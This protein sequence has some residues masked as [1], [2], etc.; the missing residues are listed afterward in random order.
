[1]SV[2]V[3]S[4]SWW[5]IPPWVGLLPMIVTTSSIAWHQACT[6]AFTAA[7]S[8]WPPV[9]NGVGAVDSGGAGA[10]HV[11]GGCMA[12]LASILVGQRPQVRCPQVDAMSSVALHHV[13]CQCL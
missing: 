4:A 6:G 8:T 2:P 12:L 9:A 3:L 1:M 10:V 11:V 5:A 7:G 13:D